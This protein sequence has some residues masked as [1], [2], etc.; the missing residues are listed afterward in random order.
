M[1]DFPNLANSDDGVC[2][3]KIQRLVLWPLQSRPPT[4]DPLRRP[5]DAAPGAAAWLA[6]LS[7]WS[8]C[9][10]VTLATAAA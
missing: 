10:V 4:H 6:A 5:A 1:L 7:A 9:F 8:L 3:G 2:F